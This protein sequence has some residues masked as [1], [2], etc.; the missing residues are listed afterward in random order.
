MRD[1]HTRLPLGAL[2]E[3]LLRVAASARSR[4]RYVAQLA[5]GS[6]NAALLPGGVLRL[7]KIRTAADAKPAAAQAGGA[8]PAAAA[9][10]GL[11]AA[12]SA[13]PAAEVGR[14]PLRTLLGALCLLTAALALRRLA[15]LSQPA[16]GG[17]APARPAGLLL[18]ALAV[19]AGAAEVAPQGGAA[20]GACVERGLDLLHPAVRPWRRPEFGKPWGQHCVEYR[21]VCFDQVR[22]WGPTRRTGGPVGRAEQEARASGCS[23]G[24]ARA[25]GVRRPAR[26]P[27]CARR[28]LPAGH[29]LRRPPPPAGRR[30]LAR[31]RALPAQRLLRAA[32]AGRHLDPD[33]RLGG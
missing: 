29:S 13:G 22:R 9:G 30:H 26:C 31:P 33:L 14:S 28:P 10:A 5:D 25:R 2:R 16:K 18:L 19:G 24:C 12:A 23:R 32:A 11:A 6:F 1:R 17:R 3:M 27:A 8:Q 21:R 20:G 15:A 7:A 4:E